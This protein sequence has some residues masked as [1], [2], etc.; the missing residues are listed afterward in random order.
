MRTTLAS[1]AGAAPAC[2]SARPPPISNAMPLA[3]KRSLLC[4]VNT[5]QCECGAELRAAMVIDY[6]ETVTRTRRALLLS[7]DC[8]LAIASGIGDSQRGEACTGRGEFI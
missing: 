4:I 5:P 1:F 2:A 8:A 7:R 6:S 3:A